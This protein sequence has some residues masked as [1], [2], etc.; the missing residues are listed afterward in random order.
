[1]LLIGGIQIIFLGVIGEYLEI[2]FIEV[3][4]R[5]LYFIDEYSGHDEDK[6]VTG[7][8]ITKNFDTIKRY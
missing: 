8:E 1:M 6:E 5:T 7:D 4:R 2:V 3:K